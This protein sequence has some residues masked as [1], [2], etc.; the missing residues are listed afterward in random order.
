MKLN[1]TSVFGLGVLL[2]AGAARADN[3]SSFIIIDALEQ[4]GDEYVTWT[5]G[6]TNNATN[7]PA[8]CSAGVGKYFFYTAGLTAASKE[9]MTRTLLSAFLAGRK[10][11]FTVK[12]STCYNNYPVISS[13]SVDKD[14]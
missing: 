10:V 2:V 11:Q 7:N 13:V 4:E 14:Q 12:S 9:L 3:Y 5:T 8:S 1:L 6:V